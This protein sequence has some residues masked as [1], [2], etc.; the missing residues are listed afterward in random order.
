[1][2][3]KQKLRAIPGALQYCLENADILIPRKVCHNHNTGRNH[4]AKIHR[5]E[6]ARRLVR[7]YGRQRVEKTLEGLRALC[8]VPPSEWRLEAI[9]AAGGNDEERSV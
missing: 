5:A 6:L 9:L 1:M 2:L 7:I 4:D 8:K 3:S